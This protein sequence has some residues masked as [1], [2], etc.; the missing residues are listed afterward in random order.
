[1]TS[2]SR[3]IGAVVKHRDV[4]G[5]GK[6]QPA[7]DDDAEHGRNDSKRGKN[8]I[9]LKSGFS[10]RSERAALAM[11]RA[12]CHCRRT[13]T[14]TWC[15]CTGTKT[16]TTTVDRQQ[17]KPVPLIWANCSRCFTS[18]NLPLRPVSPLVQS[19]GSP[20]SHGPGC[21]APAR[22]FLQIGPSSSVGTTD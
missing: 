9:W 15:H 4:L 1:M 19:H 2:P 22:I 17:T 20:T 16:T 7:L 12:W 6:E 21:E 18:P 11:M 10:L 13:K 8:A 5:L 3:G 14:T